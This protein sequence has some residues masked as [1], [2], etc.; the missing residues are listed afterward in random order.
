[1]GISLSRAALAAVAL[2]ILVTGFFLVRRHLLNG[3][4]LLRVAIATAVTVLLLSPVL[5]P[6]FE[7]RFS[8]VDASDIGAD[9][10]TLTRAVTTVSALDE[11]GKHPWFGGGASSFQLSFDWEDLGPEWEGSAWIGNTELRVLHDAGIF[12]LVAFTGF[13]VLLALR[14]RE[15]LKQKFR[16]ELLA[17]LLSGLVY[18]IT[19]QTTEGTLLAFPWIQLGLVGCLVALPVREE[20]AKKVA[21]EGAPS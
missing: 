1:V 11:V 3:R 9:P 14:S 21:M 12:G 19:F 2:V 7:E 18:C 5:L 10:K 13:L 20:D 16:I 17:L 15:R 6:H 4:L 8:T